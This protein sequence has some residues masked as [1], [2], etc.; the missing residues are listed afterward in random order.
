VNRRFLLPALLSLATAAVLASEPPPAGR[1]YT[2]G[3]FD[4]VVLDGSAT[5]QFRQ[6][7]RDEVVVEGDD[8]VQKTISVELRGATLL[9][10]TEG[11]WKFWSSRQRL[12]LWVQMRDLKSLQISG[13]ADFVASDAVELKSLRIAISGSAVTRFDRLRA[14]ELRF[15]VSGSGDGH[16]NGS[17]DELVVNVSGRSDFFGEQLM[18]RNARIAISGL[19]KIKVW[20]T[21]ELNAGIS[22]IGTVDYW[23]NPTLTRRTSGI[24]SFNDMGAKPA[25]R[26]P[27]AQPPQPPQPPQ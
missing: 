27:P 3:P 1:S 26:P 10:R 15:I 8:E 19:G 5:V 21:G 12:K 25:P 13:A 23:G 20:A 16:F 24:G 7:E 11:G 4:S 14:E 17:V 18:A 2:P 9:L 22:G 6:G